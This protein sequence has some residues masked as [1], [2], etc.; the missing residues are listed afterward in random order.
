MTAVTGSEK[1][2]N[3]YFASPSNAHLRVRDSY[4]ASIALL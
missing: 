4:K 3:I 1:N 2:V